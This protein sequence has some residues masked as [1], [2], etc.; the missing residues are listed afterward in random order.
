MKTLTFLIFVI[1][2]LKFIQHI[3]EL[4]CKSD[5]EPFE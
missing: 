4:G 1:I 5:K 3:I 2:G